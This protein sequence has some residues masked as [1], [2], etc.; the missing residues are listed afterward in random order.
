MR[1]DCLRRLTA[2]KKRPQ[3]GECWGRHS[4]NAMGYRH[5]VVLQQ[6]RRGAM[7]PTLAGRFLISF[8][9]KVSTIDH[10]LRFSREHI[11]SRPI[12]IHATR[13]RDQTN[14]ASFVH[15]ARR[16]TRRSLSEL[17]RSDDAYQHQT[18]SA[19]VRLAHLQMRRVP[20]H[21]KA[22]RGDQFKEM[23]VQRVAGACLA[24]LR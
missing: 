18:V 16:D 10:R 4:S 23:A 9:L 14:H 13:P 8:I 11:C 3:Q 2:L 17:R 24:A 1:G 15:D 5:S 20:S 19:G 12:T 22:H 7:V 6:S 21:R